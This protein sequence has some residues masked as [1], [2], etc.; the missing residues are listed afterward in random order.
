MDFN[1]KSWGKISV[2]AKDF[3][4]QLLALDP[5]ERLSASSALNH[6]WITELAHSQINDPVIE[7]ALSNIRRF[8]VD[9]DIKQ[10]AYSFVVG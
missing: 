10:L 1:G 7:H 4:Q 8:Q 6:Q 5:A 3:I 2:Q 9:N